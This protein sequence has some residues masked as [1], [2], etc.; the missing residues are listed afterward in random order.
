LINLLEILLFS[1]AAGAFFWTLK[2][3]AQRRREAEHDAFLASLA[4]YTGQQEETTKTDD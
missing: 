3:K 4:R 2:A 1:V